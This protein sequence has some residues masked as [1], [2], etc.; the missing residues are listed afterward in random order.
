MGSAQPLG[1]QLHF[2]TSLMVKKFSECSVWASLAWIYAHC[3]SL[4]P[5][6]HHCEEPIPVSCTPSPWVPAGW[7]HPLRWNTIGG[8][9]KVIENTAVDIFQ[10]HKTLQI[11]PLLLKSCEDVSS[12]AQKAAISY[13]ILCLSEKSCP[14]FE[15]SPMKWFRGKSPGLAF[16]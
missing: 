11:I 13:N 12:G 5:T 10:S 7:W 16:W 14:R 4:P 3:L 9:R 8:E 6:T 2:L 1:N 15:L